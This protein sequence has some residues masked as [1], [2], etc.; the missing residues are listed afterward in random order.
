[1]S[2]T[3]FIPV[4]TGRDIDLLINI[5]LPSIQ[6]FYQDE[7]KIFI[8]V[9]DKDYELL[10]LYLKNKDN[11][12]IKKDTEILPIKKINSYYYQMALKLQVAKFITTDFYIVFDAD[13]LLTKKCYFTNFIT[14]T[15]N[16]MSYKCNYIKINKIQDWMKRSMKYLEYKEQ[17]TFSTNQTPFIFK[18]ILVENMCS[19]IDVNDLIIN[20]KCS[21]Y[22][23]HQVYLMKNNLFESNYVEKQFSNLNI[24]Y[25]SNKLEIRALQKLAIIAF[26][27]KN[28][29]YVTG[30]IQSRINVHNKL[31]GVIKHF[32]P[33][34]TYS[35][36]RIAVLTTIIGEKYLNRYRNAIKIKKD[37]CKYNNYDFV[38][39][40]IPDS[41]DI[42]KKMG[43]KKL[44]W[45][46][47][48]KLYE[49]LYTC[50]YDYIFLSDADVVLTNRDIRLEDLI[51]KYKLDNHSCLL[52]TDYN[53]INTG[54]VIWRNCPDT[55]NIL[56]KMLEIGEKQIRY[57]IRKP[58][59][60]KG[61]YEQ[62]NLIHLYNKEIEIRKQI[63]IIPQFELNSYSKLCPK[64]L[65]P[66]V[67][68]KIMGK[69]NRC[70]WKPGDFLIHFAG[71]NY[72]INNKFNVN[73][74]I[75]IKKFEQE[76]F[77]YIQSKEGSDYGKII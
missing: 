44:G 75:A 1:M 64:L 59:L 47:I 37:Y 61:I 19:E 3:F 9:A 70:N 46:K 45:I 27:N 6:Y 77:K 10:N 74:E 11:I 30:C 31:K 72:I 43:N 56:N 42:K 36:K 76:Y 69:P 38:F 41:E 32:I 12:T 28:P 20:K 39:E 63:K 73:C 4:A 53:T 65:K 67:L 60:P 66:N 18:K 5:C 58:F 48:H 71:M 22:T 23:L 13:C 33:N 50:N 51:N 14:E 25:P 57:D 21:E 54:N 29:N 35:T 7:Y 26:K 16:T 55:I 62:P 15:K 34:S 2:I 52:T 40:Y 17:I 24:N 49:L 8:C 68:P